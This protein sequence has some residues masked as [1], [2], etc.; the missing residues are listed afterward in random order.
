[1]TLYISDT[2]KHKAYVNAFIYLIIAL[3]FVIFGAVY[4]IF[5]HEVYS[6]HMIYAFVYPLAGGCLVYNL[7]AKF[8]KKYPNTLTQNIYNSG[9]ATLT[10]GSIVQGIIEIYGTTNECVGV[11]FFVGTAMVLT[12]CILYIFTRGK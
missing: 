6:Y 2:N 3:F 1:M 8:G 12:G 9:I 5:S 11:Y 10:I 4:E 7:I